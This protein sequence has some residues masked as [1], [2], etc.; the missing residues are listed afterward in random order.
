MGFSL[1]EFVQGRGYRN[2][3]KFVY[4]WGA[5]V[6]LLGALFKLQHWPG[7]GIMLTLG[8]SV[9]A[10]IFFLSA[11]EPL[12]DEV[13]WT[14]VYPELA[15]ITDENSGSHRDG[16]GAAGASI[17]PGMLESVIT[18]A[19]NKSG[20]SSLGNSG[21]V[22]QPAP[23]QVQPVQAAPAAGG[24][25]AG[26]VFTAKFNEMLEKAEIGPELFSKISVG[27]NRLSEA[28]NGIAQISDAVSSTDTFTRNMQRAGGA[29]GKF[30]ESYE[31]S[32]Q[33]VFRA[34]KVLSDS[35]DT[36]AASVSETGKSFSTGISEIVKNMG[37]GLTN[38]SN[39][40]VG[41]VTEAGKQIEDLNKSISTL[42]AAHE[43][44]VK[45]MSKRL[46][47]SESLSMGVDDLMKRLAK[48]VEDSQR[49]S[50]SVAK[51]TAN[52][53]QLNTIYGN[54]LSAMGSMGSH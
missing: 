50:E 24:A 16:R 23:V 52:V 19:L 27:L 38:A 28:S 20:V 45:N 6:V 7:A 37:A 25:S 53:S 43:S 22:A 17:D 26:L 54:M 30:A 15:G 33:L 42:N 5:A 13:D 21:V 51:M 31:N 34:A 44:Q 3:M 29:V 48:T 35:F 49:Y 46:E 36:T 39:S 11:F 12:V 8:M 9:E 47:Q 40:I 41:G 2:I 1:S 32:G 4:G 14:L 18:S 10:L